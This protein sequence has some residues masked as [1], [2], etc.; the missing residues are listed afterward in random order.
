MPLSTEAR[1]ETPGRDAV[2]RGYMP[3]AD[4]PTYDGTFQALRQPGKP[5][6]PSPNG[7]PDAPSPSIPRRK[8]RRSSRRRGRAGAQ[9]TTKEPE[10]LRLLR[11]RPLPLGHPLHQ[12]VAS[13]AQVSPPPFCRLCSLV[14]SLFQRGRR[15]QQCL[16]ILLPILV[17]ATRRCCRCWPAHLLASGPT[18]G[19]GGRRWETGA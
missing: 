13:S 11:D 2:V 18:S 6:Q 15:R 10:L 19:A 12:Q 4:P 14:L 1:S 9:T 8:T 5:S 7:S 3:P 16:L 17:L